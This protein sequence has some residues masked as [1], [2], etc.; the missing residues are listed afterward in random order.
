MGSDQVTYAMLSASQ[1]GF[2][3]ERYKYMRAFSLAVSA[4][5]LMKVHRPWE[6]RAA[7]DLPVGSQLSALSESADAE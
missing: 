6:R 1:Y 4:H 3:S 7:P 2:A 5:D